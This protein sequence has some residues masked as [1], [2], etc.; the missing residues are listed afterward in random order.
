MR[1]AGHAGCGAQTGHARNRT[2]G[3]ARQPLVWR[4]RCRAHP[5]TPLAVC[6]PVYFSLLSLL[7]VSKPARPSPSPTRS[8][9]TLHFGADRL[10]GLPVGRLLLGADADLQVAKFPWRNAHIRQRAPCWRARQP[11]PRRQVH[12]RGGPQGDRCRGRPA[13]ERPSPLLRRR[14]WSPSSSQ[15][16]RPHRRAAEAA[17]CGTA[18]S[19]ALPRTWPRWWGKEWSRAAIRTARTPGRRPRR[20]RAR[21][22]PT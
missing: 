2:A 20:R 13:P 14:A 11:H 17:L 19:R 16:G 4:G 9:P 12:R 22:A 8:A 5:S 18:R 21:R 15:R 10:P 1:D 7:A 3:T 6:G